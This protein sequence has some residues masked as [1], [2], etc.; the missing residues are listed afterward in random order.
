MK[1]T[2]PGET[3]WYKYKTAIKHGGENNWLL[4]F[5]GG[6]YV[7]RESERGRELIREPRVS[8]LLEREGVEAA[9]S[10]RSPRRSFITHSLRIVSCDNHAY[11][12]LALDAELRRDNAFV[13]PIAYPRHWRLRDVDTLD[14]SRPRTTRAIRQ[15]FRTGASAARGANDPHLISRQHGQ[16]NEITTSAFLNYLTKNCQL[17]NLNSLI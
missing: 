5:A 15:T 2:R 3:P 9:W 12:S 4:F 1:H 8:N 7:R 6:K 13:R 17:N 10:A 16:R 11:N 14:L